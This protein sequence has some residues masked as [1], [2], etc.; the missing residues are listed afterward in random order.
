MASRSKQVQQSARQF[1]KMSIVDGA[2]SADRVAGVLQYIEKH[3]PSESVAILK[4]YQR[5]IASEFARREARI[6]HAGPAN[7]ALLAAI[8]ASMTRKY[9]RPVS[10]VARRNDDLLAGVRIRVGDDVY[11]SSVASQLAAL[12]SSV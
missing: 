5:L 12:A 2:V 11:E 4:A 3:R 9:N 8:A 6:E 10:A 1:L 7:P